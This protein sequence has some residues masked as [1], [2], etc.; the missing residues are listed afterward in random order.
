MILAAGR[1]DRMRPLTDKVP[2]PLLCVGGK[3]LIEYHIEALADA[4]IQELIIN[5]AHLGRQIEQALGEGAR[6]GVSVRYLAE[7]PGALETGGGIYNA[8]PLLGSEPFIVVNADIWT[9]YPFR[10]LPRDPC[11]VAHLVL[12][13]NPMQHPEGDFVLTDGNV[14]DSGAPRLTFSGIGVYRRE[15][16][17]GCTAGRF[18]L[19]PLLREAMRAQGVTGEHFRGGWFDVGTPERLREL[20][21]MLSSVT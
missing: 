18:P 5:H 21:Q 2:K 3:P 16:F 15:L 6:W 19:A 17:S 10:A 4:G 9:R 12:V 8:L 20:D 7:P 14:R 11:G 1:G 13:D